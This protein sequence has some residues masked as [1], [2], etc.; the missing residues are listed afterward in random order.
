[1]VAMP[2]YY[3]IHA[4]AVAEQYER[5]ARARVTP[6]KPLPVVEIEARDLREGDVIVLES[7]A[8]VHTVRDVEAQPRKNLARIWTTTGQTITYSGLVLVARQEV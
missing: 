3:A 7:G 4:A 6:A 8:P 1:M 2:G 5:E